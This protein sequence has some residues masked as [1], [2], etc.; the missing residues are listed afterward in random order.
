MFQAWKANVKFL[1]IFLQPA[2]HARHE[3]DL[4][5]S[6][7]KLLIEPGM[8][9]LLVKRQQETSIRTLTKAKGKILK[10]CA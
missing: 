3:L 5:G 9:L 6:H 2:K 10:H 4:F 8:D 7:T 1:K